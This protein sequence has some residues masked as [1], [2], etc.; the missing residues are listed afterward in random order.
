MEDIGTFLGR[1]MSESKIRRQ[2]VKDYLRTPLRQMLDEEIPRMT[3]L[4]AKQRKE[5]ITKAVKARQKYGTKPDMEE[6]EDIVN[7]WGEMRPRMFKQLQDE[8]RLFPTAEVLYHPWAAK[9]SALQEAYKNQKMDE[10][11]YYREIN[12]LDQMILQYPEYETDEEEM[13]SEDGEL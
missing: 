13:Q 4:Q 6:L 1:V 7:G 2:E 3:E 11:A 5:W 10:Q 9:M 8:G 12:E